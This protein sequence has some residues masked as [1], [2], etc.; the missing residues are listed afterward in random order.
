MHWELVMKA[1]ME[2][3]IR[4][5]IDGGAAPV[6]VAEIR[7]RRSA[8]AR[9][10]SRRRVSGRPDWARPSTG[11]IAAVAAG[12]T[13]VACA[14][15]VIAAGLAGPTARSTSA[16]AV[17]LTAATV[18]H[19]ASE[20]RAALAASGRALI[21][22]RD[23]Q[24]GVLQ[25]NGTD[26]ITFSGRNWND[27]FSQSFPASG[28][29]PAHTQFAINRIVNGQAYYYIAGRTARLE[30]YHDTNP[31]NHPDIAV[32]DPRTVLSALAP[33]ARF[34]LVGYQVVGG[35]RV[36]HLRAT[37]SVRLA[38]LASLPDVQPGDSITGLQV[39]ADGHGVVRRM[40][41]SLRQVNIVYPFNPRTLPAQL[42]RELTI[43][44]TVTMKKIELLIRAYGRDHPALAGGGRAQRQVVLTTLT[45]SFLDIGQ[46]QVIT[47]PRHAI[48]QFGLG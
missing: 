28:G 25:D 15:A 7:A 9:P 38:G 39:W 44:K 6:T 48:Q 4:D 32:P 36:E 20:S 46:P 37:R 11:R 40:T 42:K 31:T 29:Q 22:Y 23:T 24:G 5:L 18:R 17:I 21:T 34:Q 33:S 26:D 35:V 1:D 10:A 19:L 43:G 2:Q 30:W 16:P 12:A 14:G 45:V 8:L 47:A 27:A 41:L 3:G 13:A